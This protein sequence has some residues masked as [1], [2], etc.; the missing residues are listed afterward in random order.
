MQPYFGQCY[1]VT[2]AKLGMKP[3]YCGGLLAKPV[4]AHTQPGC[5]N[6]GKL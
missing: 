5:H 2:G 6:E 4:D 1:L 3:E